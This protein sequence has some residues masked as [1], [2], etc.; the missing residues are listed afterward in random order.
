M[1]P[2]WLDANSPSSLYLHPPLSPPPPLPPQHL[3]LLVKCFVF[4][5]LFFH[6]VF[7]ITTYCLLASFDVCFC[8]LCERVCACTRIAFVSKCAPSL[9]SFH[10]CFDFCMCVFLCERVCFIINVAFF[11]QFHHFCQLSSP[12]INSLNGWY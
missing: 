5:F 11:Q 2:A 8:K 4:H 3:W 7:F 6:L 9:F 10:M 1:D 12:Q